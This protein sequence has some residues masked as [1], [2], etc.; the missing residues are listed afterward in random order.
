MRSTSYFRKLS[1]NRR[2]RA[3]K[4][5]CLVLA[6]VLSVVCAPTLVRL[7][8]RG[9]RRATETYWTVMFGGVHF[10]RTCSGAG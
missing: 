9:S 3:L 4:N 5:Q 1:D 2:T 10:G 7:R 8:A 6:M